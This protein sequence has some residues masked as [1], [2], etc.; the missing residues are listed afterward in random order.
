M[1]E[2]NK[3]VTTKKGESV[4]PFLVQNGFIYCF[5]KNG[6]VVL[7]TFDEFDFKAEVKKE[8]HYVMPSEKIVTPT[9]QKEEPKV[10]TQIG[11]A[12]V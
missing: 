12:H 3:I 1:F 6:S 8:E 10:V 11:R 9:L 5:T 7:K 2:L 4:K